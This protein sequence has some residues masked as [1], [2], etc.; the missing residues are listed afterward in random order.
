MRNVDG[1]LVVCPDV[2]GAG[3]R[4]RHPN[5]AARGVGGGRGEV[6]LGTVGE[7]GETQY[8]GAAR[9]LRKQPIGAPIHGH[10]PGWSCK[11]DEVRIA[12]RVGA[13]LQ[14]I[15]A[16]AEVPVRDQPKAVPDRVAREERVALK[17]E[18]AE[19]GLRIGRRAAAA[20]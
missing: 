14:G 10:R 19:R 1:G 6:A 15:A 11:G 7:A 18:V 12:G 20:D 5:N 8:T 16:A 3:E 9:A 17:H 4:D 13:Q 2:A